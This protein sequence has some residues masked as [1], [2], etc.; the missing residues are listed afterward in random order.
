MFNRQDL[1]YNVWSYSF[2]IGERVLLY[3][4]NDI[5]HFTHTIVSFSTDFLLQQAFYSNFTSISILANISSK[6]EK[7]SFFILCS[8]IKFKLN[9]I[10][11][12]YHSH[13][14]TFTAYLYIIEK[15]FRSIK[16]VRIK[17]EL[18]YIWCSLSEE[19]K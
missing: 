3:R 18:S 1:R 7:Y 19:N 15:H 12:K 14:C 10:K 16:S 13:I 2:V 17:K 4:V 5:Y 11:F 6:W 8:L 9:L